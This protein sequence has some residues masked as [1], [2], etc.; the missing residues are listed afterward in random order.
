MNTLNQ[1]YSFSIIIAT[2][3]SMKILPKVIDSI[4]NQNFNIS[5]IEIIAVD[6]G[7]SDGTKE[8]LQEKKITIFD[9]PLKD[10]VNAKH[11]GLNQAHGRY[12]VFID[13]DEVLKNHDFF[14]IRKEIFHKNDEVKI[15]LP[16]GYETPIGYHPINSY[17]NEFGD[18]FSFFIY[19]ISKHKDYFTK[20][21]KKWYKN[22]EENSEYIKFEIELLKY[23]PLIE[24]IAG[25][26]C[27]DKQY[28]TKR[29]ETEIKKPEFLTHL[30]FEICK[31]YPYIV[32][33]K[34]DP[35]IHFSS[36]KISTYLN[37][38]KWRIINNIF[39]KN[40]LGESGF[41]GREKYHL[42][43]FLKIKKYFFIPYSFS[44]ILPFFDSILLSISRRNLIWLI[45][46]PLVIFTSVF[47][48]YNL[49]LKMFGFKPTL[50]TYDGKTKIIN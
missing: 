22:L 38:I 8:Y 23:I 48:V 13:H 31:D 40:K 18:P 27:F 2:Y 11:I 39:L 14:K 42:N 1:K 34:K 9:N 5:E 21:I 50:K 15:I 17:I 4:F 6:G 3:N 10:P 26:S 33:T 29:F 49:I 46:L 28:V 20:S 36:D 24:L 25:A 7:S 37:K 12:V 43:D 19:G 35:I 41:S 32:I 44:L 45:H 16:T 30:F 47:I